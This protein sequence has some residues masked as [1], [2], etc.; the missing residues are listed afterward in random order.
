MLEQSV[1]NLFGG[2]GVF[3]CVFICSCLPI[4]ETKIAIPLGISTSIWGTNAMSLWQ[5]FLVSLLGSSFAGIILIFVFHFF[6]KRIRKRNKNKKITSKIE[7]F[8]NIKAKKFQDA[9]KSKKILFL[10]LLLALPVPFAGLYSGAMLCVLLNL[11]LYES[12]LVV[13]F[14]NFL[15]CLII[16]IVCFA[17][18]EFINLF[19]TILIIFICLTATFNI[20]CCFFNKKTHKTTQK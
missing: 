8:L 10:T 4:V 5:S 9:K 7:N 11:K 2:F 13:L 14:G 17:F 20:I 15:N 18:F 6:V 3:L 12:I 19:L 1:I 16:L